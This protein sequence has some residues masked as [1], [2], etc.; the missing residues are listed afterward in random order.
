MYF[1]PTHSSPYMDPPGTNLRKAMTLPTMGAYR[2]TMNQ[3]TGMTTRVYSCQSPRRLDLRLPD[4]PPLLR[5]LVPAV[6]AVG[7]EAARRPAGRDGD[8][9]V[10]T[11]SATTHHLLVN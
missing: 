6:A 5:D 4:R 9:A 3:M 10:S 11:T 1:S 2:K 8:G 7:V